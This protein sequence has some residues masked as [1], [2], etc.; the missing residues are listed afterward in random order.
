MGHPRRSTEDSGKGDLNCGSATEVSEGKNI[1][2]LE[3]ILVVF[4]PRMWP[5]SALVQ[6]NLPEVKLKS[7]DQWH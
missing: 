1:S 3:T 4:W 6:K 7:L 2:G 5:L